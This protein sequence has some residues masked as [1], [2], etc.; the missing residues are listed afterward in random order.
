[1]SV[2]RSNFNV[3]GLPRAVSQHNISRLDVVTIL[4]CLHFAIHLIGGVFV[5]KERDS[6]SSH[7]VV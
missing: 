6:C 1:M 2:I 4:P 7:V 3:Q 5:F